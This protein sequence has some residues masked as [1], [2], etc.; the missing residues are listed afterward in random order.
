M[1]RKTS[2]V[3]G[4]A[5]THAEVNGKKVIYSFG[6]IVHSFVLL[7]VIKAENKSWDGRVGMKL[8][9]HVGIAQNARHSLFPGST[10]QFYIY[11]YPM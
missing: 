11:I 3:L 5:R 10:L 9:V 4:P 7:T 2:C 6:G 8:H 1:Q